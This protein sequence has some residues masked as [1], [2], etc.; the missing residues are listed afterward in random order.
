MRFMISLALG[1]AT[2]VAALAATPPAPPLP[3]ESVYQLAAPLTDQDGR[4][5]LLADKRGR[6][7]LVLM[8]YTSCKFICPTIIDTVLDL[9][10]KLTPAERKRLGVLMISLDPQRDD[11][12]ALK[13]TADK[14]RLDLT[15]WTLAQPRPGDLRALAGVL[16]VR[17]RPLADGEIN[18]T[19][20]LV[21]LDAE[22]RIVARSAKTGGSVD[23]AFLE[24]VRRTL[25]E[26]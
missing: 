19:G 3:R 7:Q 20:Q 12:A 8:F 13:A 9:D 5:L 26:P 15:R 16:G 23:P 18:H 22:G 24:R 11:A 2:A 6:T 1:L 21:L 17:F 4:R 14:R 25:V 10:D